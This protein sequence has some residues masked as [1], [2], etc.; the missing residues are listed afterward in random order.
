MQC[1]VSGNMT[2]TRTTLL[3]GLGHVLHCQVGPP[4]SAHADPNPPMPMTLLAPSSISIASACPCVVR[5]GWVAIDLC[6]WTHLGRCAARLSIHLVYAPASATPPP[7]PPPHHLLVDGGRRCWSAIAT[8]VVTRCLAVALHLIMLRD[9]SL[10]LYSPFL[11][12]RPLTHICQICLYL[13]LLASAE[14]CNVGTSD[15]RNDYWQW[16]KQLS[17]LVHLYICIDISFKYTE[18]CFYKNNHALRMYDWWLVDFYDQ[19]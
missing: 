15:I 10:I 4:T 5:L 6:S 3:H 2:E 9:K 13:D 18:C 19:V 7:H 12:S 11:M 8:A 1:N 16:S 17:D 14:W